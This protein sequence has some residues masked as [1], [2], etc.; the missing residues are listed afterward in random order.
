L[1]GFTSKGVARVKIRVVGMESM[2]LLAKDEYV[3]DIGEIIVKSIF[4]NTK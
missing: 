4:N 3:T 1:L 2:I